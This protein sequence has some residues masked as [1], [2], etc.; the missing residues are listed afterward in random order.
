MK[1]L[2]LGCSGF[3]G[4]ELVPYL[5]ELGHTLTRVSRRDLPSSDPRLTHLILDPADPASWQRQELRQALAAADGV[6]NLAGE[7]IAEQRWSETH[8]RVL[9]ASREATTA[10]LV[11]AM[12]ALETPPRVLVQGSAVGFYGT[13]E[14][15]SYQ[16]DSP[17]GSDFLAQI[18]QRWE[19]AAAA[20]VDELARDAYGRLDALKIPHY[21]SPVRCGKAF[22][23]L[24]GYAEAKRRIIAQ[25]AEQPLVIKKIELNQLLENRT[26]DIAEYEA[27][28][29]LAEYGI[30]VTNTRVSVTPVAIIAEGVSDCAGQAG[31][32]RAP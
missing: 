8:R 5:L 32:R 24:S 7:P 18:C 10:Q 4:R 22:S 26:A 29:V 15:A 19:Q 25:R 9:L 21:K 31:R 23:A 6:V 20:V 14:S 11:A 17:A 27:K 13:S 16:E 2:L 30:P 3:V 28:K 12:A 1:V